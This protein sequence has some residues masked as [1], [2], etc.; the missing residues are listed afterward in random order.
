MPIMVQVSE[1]NFSSPEGEPIFSDFHLQL[2]RGGFLCVVGGPATGKTLLLRLL[3]RELRPQHG[4]ILIDNCNITRLSPERFSR[5]R[6]QIGIVPQDP[7]LLRRRTLA[8]TLCFKLRA[9]GLAPEMTGPKA[10]EI[11]QAVG[12]FESRDRH[13]EELAPGEARILQLAL[14]ICHDPVLLLIDDPIRK[15]GSSEAERLLAVLKYIQQRHRLTVLATSREPS[16]A[17]VLGTAVVQLMLRAQET[18]PEVAPEWRLPGG[19]TAGS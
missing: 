4:Q 12:L 5:L 13:L 3:C 8:G 10:Q 6:S 15:L 19:R 18:A 16:V 11:L 7:Q 2:E 1:L 9:L 14:A 17:E